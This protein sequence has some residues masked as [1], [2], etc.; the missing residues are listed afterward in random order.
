MAEASTNYQ[1]EIDVLRG[2][3]GSLTYAGV[4]T[5]ENPPKFSGNYG[6][7]LQSL[8]AGVSLRDAFANLNDAAASVRD[9]SATVLS[10]VKDHKTPI[11]KGKA[12]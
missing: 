3:V 5:D 10:M 7:L 1:D 2:Q 4:W 6:K 8:Y 11:F 12:G 9:S